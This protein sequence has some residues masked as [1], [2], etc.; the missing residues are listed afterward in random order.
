MQDPHAGK[1]GTY[2]TDPDTGTRLTVEEWRAKQAAV[3]TDGKPA[4]AKPIKDQPAGD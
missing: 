2:Y 1:P 4:K 3:Q